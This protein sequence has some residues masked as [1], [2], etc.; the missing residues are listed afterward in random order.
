VNERILEAILA[1]LAVVWAVLLM[2]AAIDPGRTELASSAT[3]IIGAVFV[4]A[5]GALGI[6][7]KRNGN[8]GGK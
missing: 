4:A 3:P 2:A 8:G 1:L 6:A 7:R 5:F